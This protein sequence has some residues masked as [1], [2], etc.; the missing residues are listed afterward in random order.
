MPL[1]YN[2]PQHQRCKP[3]GPW[4][5]GWKSELFSL[6]SLFF[7]DVMLFLSSFNATMHIN[8]L[9]PSHKLTPFITIIACQGKV[10]HMFD[11]VSLFFCSLCSKYILLF[12]F[13]PNVKFFWSFGLCSR[14]FQPGGKM[15]GEHGCFHFYSLLF[16]SLH[17]G[18]RTS[19]KH[20][21][22]QRFE[23]TGI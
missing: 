14:S 16:A 10:S 2:K 18:K 1:N 13:L 17:T 11:V 6:S 9:L 20:I 21:R 22:S 12:H 5:A 4:L 8:C 23:H 7:T 15:R 3:H 19:V